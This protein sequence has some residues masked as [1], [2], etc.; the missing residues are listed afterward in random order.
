MCI[1]SYLKRSES[2]TSSHCWIT[3]VRHRMAWPPIRKELGSALGFSQF[4]RSGWFVQN[5]SILYSPT[6]TPHVVSH[7]RLQHTEAFVT[8]V[9]LEPASCAGPQS[10][11]RHLSRGYDPRGPMRK[12]PLLRRGRGGF[13]ADSGSKLG[14]SGPNQNGPKLFGSKAGQFWIGFRPVHIMFGA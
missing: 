13:W 11:H 7:W 5:R 2:D 4:V 12:R 8:H 6:P 14:A 10:I 3:R 1:E 9:F